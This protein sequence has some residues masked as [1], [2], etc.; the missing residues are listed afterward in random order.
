MIQIKIFILQTSV[1]TR[2]AFSLE[3]VHPVIL[4]PWRHT[5]T[6]K[7]TKERKG[8]NYANEDADHRTKKRVKRNTSLK[9]VA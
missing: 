5:D 6:D 9:M 4:R 7:Q 2:A 1:L 3:S 8:P